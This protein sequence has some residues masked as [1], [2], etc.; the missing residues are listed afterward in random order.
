MEKKI[1]EYEKL[2]ARESARKMEKSERERLIVLHREVMTDFQHE[3]LIHLIV[4]LFFAFLAIEF[5][6]ITMWTI[7]EFGLMIELLPLY[8]IVLI[9]IILTFF[10]V[11]HYYFLENHIQNLYRYTEKICKQI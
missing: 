9:L 11:K 2:I 3:R 10:Y 8:I 1:H 6:I 7:I 4:T 5:T